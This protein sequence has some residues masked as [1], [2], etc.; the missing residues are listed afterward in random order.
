MARFQHD[1]A[2]FSLTFNADGSYLA[3]GSSDGTARVFL[4]SRKVEVQRLTPASNIV[5]A[6]GDRFLATYTD[7]TVKVWEPPWR[8][9][10]RLESRGADFHAGV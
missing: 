7:G 5:L 3:T 2:V 9:R 1:E 4:L 6:S 10:S 8:R